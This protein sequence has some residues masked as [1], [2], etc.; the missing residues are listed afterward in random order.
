LLDHAREIVC[1]H[2]RSVVG[3][4]RISIPGE[5]AALRGARLSFGAGKAK[6]PPV[7]SGLPPQSKGR[8]ALASQKR[9]T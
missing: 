5:R 4:L 3:G 6:R 8:Q 9:W 1:V 2:G 7:P